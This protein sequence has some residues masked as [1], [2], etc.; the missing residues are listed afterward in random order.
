VQII[1]LPEALELFKELIIY[2]GTIQLM[3]HIKKNNFTSFDEIKKS[4][5][6]KIQRTQWL[7]VGGQLMTTTD[8]DK[9]KRDIKSGKIQTWQQLHE[10]YK[11]TGANYMADKLSHAYTSLLEILNITSKQFTEETFKLLLQKATNTKE[12][13]SKSIYQSREKDYTNPFRKMMYRTK[14]EM[15]KMF[16]KIGIIIQDHK[17]KNIFTN[18]TFS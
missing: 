2:Y 14:T 15:D 1:K 16:F 11:K 8:I 7:N 3:G 4:L 13:M 6:T 9:L 5:S 17:Y 12:W 10:V 18:K